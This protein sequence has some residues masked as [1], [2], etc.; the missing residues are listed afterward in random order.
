MSERF[1]S[2]C[3]KEVLTVINMSEIPEMM[4]YYEQFFV[5]PNE[6]EKE[7]IRNNARKVKGELEVIEKLCED[8]KEY[9]EEIKYVLSTLEKDP[10]NIPV[11]FK[12][13]SI[14]DQIVNKLYFE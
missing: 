3:L 11:G 13:V 14:R 7:K 4:L 10:A 2:G 6:T 5:E 9:I 1:E 8:A 12:L